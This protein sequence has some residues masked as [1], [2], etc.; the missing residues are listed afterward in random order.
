MTRRV[1]SAGEILSDLNPEQRA[2]VLHQGS[3]LLVIA[4]PGTGKTRVITHRLAYRV[5]NDG[6][7]PERLLALTF[8]VRAG[9][10]MK[11]RIYRL[12]DDEVKVKAGTFHALCYLILRRHGRQA[13]MT[14]SFV[15]LSPEKA[16][17]ALLTVM[18]GKNGSRGNRAGE[19]ASAL[20]WIKSGAS[21]ERAA[22]HFSL[23]EEELTSVD[24]LFRT[25]LRAEGA[26]ELD[27]LIPLAVGALRQY[28]SVRDRWREAF[29][30]LLVDEY[31]DVNPIQ[32]ELLRLLFPRS[33]AV[34]A[35]GDDDQGIYGWRMAGEG[36]LQDF[37]T[38]FAGGSTVVLSR[39]YR[40]T[41]H[42][43]RAASALIEHNPGRI[44]RYLTTVRPAGQPPI[45]CVVED[46]NT[47][48]NWVA[49]T[50]AELARRQQ[51]PWSDFV[52]LFRTHMQSRPIE[53]GLLRLGIPYA[54]HAGISF[55]RRPEIRRA[56]LYLRLV[57]DAGDDE[58]TVDLLRSI[59]RMAS[60]HVHA[61]RDS[62]RERS[63]TLSS[64][65]SGDSTRVRL[66]EKVQPHVFALGNRIN[67]LS[68]LHS[69]SLIAAVEGAVAASLAHVNHESGA[70]T[71]TA[72]DNLEELSRLAATF[73]AERSTLALFVDRLR[74][75]ERTE[76]ATDR[77][78]L[79]S[80]HAC[81]GTEYPVVFLTG[82]EEGLLPHRR[83]MAIQSSLS[84]ERRLCYVGMTRAVDL[85]YL[86][87][88]R[89]RTIGRE[90]YR[91]LPSRFI[92]EMREANLQLVR[93]PVRTQLAP[94]GGGV[95]GRAT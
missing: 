60:A 11:D 94:V 50:I 58:A 69:A 13:G 3:P 40:T 95:G 91:A 57:L 77:V 1:S 54:L 70:D 66:P 63:L 38:T 12:L 2:A 22:T 55:Y 88:A 74:A 7:P 4:G 44:S 28:G 27:D 33:G 31:Q 8:T 41:K 72:Q 76:I 86:S 6:V 62:A 87:H 65:L 89:S 43:L 71:D 80:L 37:S 48:G 35:V 20:R 32:L 21:P 36:A 85:L 45:C 90:S 24:T 68:P 18:A 53:D 93:G 52:V 10:E 92:R 64:F 5:L 67:E 16:R 39:S 49:G 79:M 14:G 59:R 51:R 81:K 84:E 83:S 19:F 61:L 47:E 30:E 15:L 42:V 17:R 46:E 75:F 82:L 56:I 25:R 9:R 23:D 34:V 26:I 29:D 78:T 73:H